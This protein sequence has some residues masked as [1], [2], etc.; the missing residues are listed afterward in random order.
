MNFTL[1]A[2]LAGLCCSTR[3][4][5]K[6]NLLKNSSFESPLGSEWLMKTS[7]GITIIRDTTEKFSGQY[8]L[9]VENTV[10]GYTD[11]Y[12]CNQR[13]LA[14]SAGTWITLQASIKTRKLTGLAGIDIHY[15]NA[16][17]Q[18]LPIYDAKILLDSKGSSSD[19]KEYSIDFYVPDNTKKITVALFIKGQGSI[20]FDKLTF[21][22]SEPANLM[23][24]KPSSGAYM[25]REKN[26][27]IWFE[28]AE[29]KVYR[30]TAVPKVIIK[31]T[32]KIAGARNEWESFQ[33]V[34]RSKSTLKNCTIAFTDLIHTNK[35]SIIEKN[36]LTHY[37]IG[38]VDVKNTS[39]T[40]GVIGLNPDYLLKKDHFDLLAGIN[41]PIWINIKIP[42]GAQPGIYQGQIL[43]KLGEKTHV[44]I[45]LQITVWNFALPQKNHL[46][47]RSNFWLSLVRKYDRRDSKEILADYYENLQDHRINVFSIINLE[48]KIIDDS[49]VYFFD[50]FDRKVKN[51]FENYGFEAITVG[52]F[53]GD[54]SGW[55]FRR[56]WMGIDPESPRFKYLLK[57]YCKKLESHLSANGWLNRC[58]IAYWDEPQLDNPGFEKIVKIGRIIKEAAPNLKIFMTKWPIPELFGIVD[59]W[60]LPFTDRYFCP[61]DI[62]E[63]KL[64][65]ERIFVYHNDPYIDTPLIDKR[66]YAWKY[67]LADIDGVYAWWNLTFWQKNPYDF[68]FQVEK[69]GNREN[70][71]KPGDGVLLYPNPN[72]NGPPVNSL[73]WEIFRQGLEDYEYFWLLEQNIKSTFAHLEVN[74]RFQNFAQ[75]RVNEIINIF[76]KDYFSNWKRDVNLLY[77]IRQRTAKEIQEINRSPI[78]V[79]KTEPQEGEII[80]NNKKVKI[81]G[82]A[83]KG[84]K[85]SINGKSIAIK[86]DGSFF[87]ETDVSRDK[88][89]LIKA[90]LK[91]K[92]K[93]IERFFE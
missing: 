2:L 78:V 22:R 93:I 90:R 41:N 8:S 1:L 47:V 40:N 48:T 30:E 25:L 21:R 26:P 29:Q 62:V 89:I 12:G 16:F 65:G 77:A 6:G 28:F 17:G 5:V 51:L 11:Y 45:P 33:I 75:Y 86:N 18:R 19:W 63:R 15:L 81:F 64:L 73:R 24:K 80:S 88:H 37:I 67:R 44:K 4:D 85:I 56:K 92:E 61:Q 54:A 58:W 83:E 53:I 50:K 23:D 10:P 70:I 35:L 74:D 7:P 59:I 57:Q 55:K 49:L 36:R 20:W 31:S 68:S 13:I 84:T 27:L 42:K 14:P 38:Y 60:C 82:L 66:L 79:I 87:S 91:H 76:M 3:T 52:P 32:I 72:G 39:T 9:R 46:Y 71:L 34:V 43:F 69:K